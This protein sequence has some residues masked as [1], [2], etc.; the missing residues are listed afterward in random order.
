M[1]SEVLVRA[2]GLGKKFCRNL[3]RSLAYGM[4]DTFSDLLLHAGPRDKLRKDEFWA[5]TDINFELR[6]GE[7]LGLI[8]RNGAGKTTLLKML[9]GLLKPDRG[10]IELRG[11]I[12][13]LIA[14]NAGF[15]PLLTGRE[16]IYV[17]GSV[18]GLTRQ[19]IKSRFDEI[20]E[21][22]EMKEFIDMP[23]RSYSSGMQVRLG[24]SIA[25]TLK[26]DI[27]LL[28]EVLAVG[29][30]AFR[31]KCYARVAEVLKNAAVIFV[32]H[33]M[34][35][36]GMICT[37]GML[38]RKGQVVESGNVDNVIRRY[39][40]ENLNPGDSDVIEQ[41]VPPLEAVSVAFAPQIT[42]GQPLPITL[43]ARSQA[44]LDN[45]TI[46]LTI[47]TAEMQ[48]VFVAQGKDQ[49][50]RFSIHP[51]ENT[52]SLT[53]DPLILRAGAYFLS[54]EIASWSSPVRYYTAHLK[55]QI[56]VEGP[57]FVNEVQVPRLSAT[58]IS[59]S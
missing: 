16:N 30:V 14:L 53:I 27:L 10:H 32:S 54:L 1:S 17:N 24:F 57:S 8:G 15:N 31:N 55:Y 37:H 39:Y 45:A 26:P 2:E 4:Q 58:T 42:Y 59:Q 56:T 52:V 48:R 29:D 20:V 6:R 25:S 9:N 21:F 3:Q 47:H 33:N 43:H 7:C 49:G 38:L 23:V 36:I 28:D 11:R 5:N 44:A 51:G 19:E 40:S 12:G 35:Q 46:N 50:L 22:A 18:L 13:A 41:I 34:E